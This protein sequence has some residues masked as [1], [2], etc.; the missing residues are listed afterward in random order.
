MQFRTFEEFSRAL[1]SLA[2][3]PPHSFLGAT[4]VDGVRS[5]MRHIDQ[6]WMQS[7]PARSFIKNPITL[8]E[9]IAAIA[10]VAAPNA[11]EAIEASETVDAEISV[12]E[13]FEETIPEMTQETIPETIPAAD[14]AVADTLDSTP[15]R[16]DAPAAPVE[17]AAP[18]SE[19]SP[20]SIRVIGDSFFSWNELATHAESLSPN[21]L[22]ALFAQA[23]T[24][25][26]ARNMIEH[27]G[28]IVSLK[29]LMKSTSPMPHN[30]SKMLR[31]LFQYCL[32]HRN[33]AL[34][35]QL[36]TQLHALDMLPRP[37]AFKYFFDD[38]IGKWTAANSHAKTRKDEAVD[39]PSADVQASMIDEGDQRGYTP[40]GVA[41]D[42]LVTLL[43]DAT[44]WFCIRSKLPTQVWQSNTDA[45]PHSKEEQT[46]TEATTPPATVPT[47]SSR[48]PLALHPSSVQIDFTASSLSRRLHYLH[49]AGVPLT[50]DRVLN[51]YAFKT[52]CAL[53]MRGSYYPLA[54]FVRQLQGLNMDLHA[55]AIFRSSIQWLVQQDTTARRTRCGPS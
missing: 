25:R 48:D 2:T 3:M 13:Q 51:V 12:A 47:H 53:A 8:E 41:T 4:R 7:M 11:T 42:E 5:A 26:L 30:R 18:I 6:R 44:Y 9:Q 35:H 14:V 19:S 16:V 36:C 49:R 39:I 27:Q 34:F 37:L 33:A 31:L 55:H 21:E 52:V 24:S 40:S 46:D 45:T 17:E 38:L 15:V 1:A 54:T 23:E 28:F 29:L 10:T 20:P 43:R 32:Y 50:I 22:D